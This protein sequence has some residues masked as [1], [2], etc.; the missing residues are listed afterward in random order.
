[1]RATFL[2]YQKDGRK[3][4]DLT[5]AEPF[6]WL[7]ENRKKYPESELAILSWLVVDVNQYEFAGIQA[8]IGIDYDEKPKAEPV[9]EE[10]PPAPA[11]RPRGWQFMNEY[12]DPDGTKYHKGVKIE[13]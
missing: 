4:N 10:A 2:V 12:T 13:D 9:I 6:T 3:G 7:L 8:Q 11:K 1:M 5:T